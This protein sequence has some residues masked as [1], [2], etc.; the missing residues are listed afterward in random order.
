KA[1]SVAKADPTFTTVAAVNVTVGQNMT[2]TV[3][4]PEDA[5]GTVYA[6][7]SGELV[8]TGI[9]L[10]NGTAT[11]VV[12][13]LAY[14]KYGY[15][16]TYEGD[17]NYNLATD[18]NS[19]EIIKKDI[20][21]NVT[22]DI[23]AGASTY[24]PTFAIKNLPSDAT[25]TLTVT[26]DGKE[27]LAEVKNGGAS[28]TIPGLSVGNHDVTVTY[29]GDA[30]YGNISKSDMI[31]LITPVP[32]LEGKDLSVLYSGSAK[33]T[34][35]L[36]IDGK[37]AA[38]E[39]VSVSFNGAKLSVK[40]N[41][42]GEATFKLNSKAKIDKYDVTAKYSSAETTN[43][44]TI[45]NIIKAKNKKV[46]KSKT[47][48]VKITLSKVD[49]KYLKGKKLKIKLKGKKYKVKTNKK[50]KATWK[51]KPS[52]IKKLKVGKKYKYTVSYGKD[53]VTKKLKI[54]R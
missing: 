44:V 21:G 28:I 31:T 45:K 34:V 11:I 10:V 7:V 2:I 13:N 1:F 52:M 36:T 27:Y 43:K 50:G 46:K 32:K 8:A 23:P 49:G 54:K 24:E 5:T 42:K 26:V 3:I 14:G 12:P 19:F 4:A 15:A 25:G 22:I 48:K 18:I 47:T 30:Q 35:L 29:S 38:G 16:V 40:T 6:T 17:D 33:Y 53:T 41:S 20:S 39:I 37:P 51:V 9:P